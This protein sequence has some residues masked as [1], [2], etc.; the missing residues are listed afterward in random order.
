M[1]D[2]ELR[3]DETILLRTPGVYAKSIP[4][5]G[6]LTNKRIFLVDRAK[7]LLPPKE[8][9][10]VTIKDVQPGVNAIGD[11]TLTISVTAK[12]G[13]TRKMILTFSR[14]TGGNR[15]KERDE[16]YTLIKQNTSSSFEQVIRKVIPGLEHPKK[17]HEPKTTPRI[18]I[19]GSPIS[20]KAPPLKKIVQKETEEVPPIKKIVETVPSPMVADEI[21]SASSDFGTYCSRCGNKVPE[22]SGFCNRCGSPIVVPGSPGA[23]SPVAPAPVTRK[24]AALSFPEPILVPEEQDAEPEVVPPP[25]SVPERAQPVPG[26]TSR[27]AARPAPGEKPARRGLIARLFSPKKRLAAPRAP[28][29]TTGMKQP[30][31]K[32]PKRDFRFRPGKRALFATVLIVIVIIAVLGGYFVI[33]PNLTSGGK[34]STVSSKPTVT[35]TST[36][37]SGSTI[38]TGATIVPAVTTSVVI[39]ATG[40]WVHINYLG[41]WKGSYGMP[42]ELL[43]ATGSGDKMY[44]VLNATG[45]IQAS[46]EKLDT[47]TRHALLLEIYKDGKLLNSTTTSA[48]YG[49]VA[50]SADTTT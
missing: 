34:S 10:L 11:Q 29:A 24:T 42:E 43:N 49:T 44:E 6:I 32:K 9:P 48:S 23:V 16:W 39:P 19:V 17:I 1:A 50:L 45:T 37:L 47:S 33:L 30:S 46:F 41:S 15:I 14:S 28:A 3:N 4:F 36:S 38:S 40:V 26:A 8:I 20:Q 21:S 31:P 13:E 25:V 7:D 35:T 12:T 5:E 22:G 18:E 2:P 27:P